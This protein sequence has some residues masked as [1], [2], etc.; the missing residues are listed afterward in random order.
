MSVRAC[1]VA[2]VTACGA[3]VSARAVDQAAES[4]CAALA[5]TMQPQPSPQVDALPSQHADAMIDSEWC[6][7]RFD[8][9]MLDAV[10]LSGDSAAEAKAAQGGNASAKAGAPPQRK[11]FGASGSWRWNVLGGWGTD[12]DGTG[13]VQFGAAVSWFVV[14]DLSIDVQGNVD[15][16][17]Q[18]GPDAWGGD[19]EL[20]LRWHFLARDTWS[21]YI[22]GGCGLMW[23]DA[24]VPPDTARFNFT[25]QAGGG[26]TYEVGP[27]VRLMAGARWFH[28]SSANT[29]S[30]NPGINN[31]FLY[32]GLTVGF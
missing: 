2:G 3:S 18:D 10:A 14:D 12:A 15:Y 25:P 23:T 20:L 5:R 11:A 6:T 19:V 30:P 16:F 24:D 21:V 17:S 1:I 26:L 29:G 28:A 32:A 22:D 8:P 13:Q 27:D 31:V 7:F 9:V 4:D